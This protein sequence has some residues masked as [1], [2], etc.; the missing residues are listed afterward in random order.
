MNLIK[1]IF[2]WAVFAIVPS[3]LRAGLRP[4]ADLVTSSSVFFAFTAAC[5][6]FVCERVSPRTSE[7]SNVLASYTN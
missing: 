4:L 7:P 5:R 1:I 2:T 3:R 6:R